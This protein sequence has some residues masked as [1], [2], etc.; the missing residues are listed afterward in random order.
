VK[1]VNLWR[2]AQTTTTTALEAAQ[3]KSA[4]PYS[5]NFIFF[6]F[7]TKKDFFFSRPL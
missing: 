6:H 5:T 1:H 2:A 7:K 4:R 3:K